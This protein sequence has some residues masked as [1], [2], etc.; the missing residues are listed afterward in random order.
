V[1]ANYERYH[2]KGFEVVGIS[3]DEDKD[4]LTDVIKDEDIPW[5]NLFE[6]PKDGEAGIQPTAEYYGISSLPTAILVGRDGKVLSLMARGEILTEL[7][8]QQF[9]KE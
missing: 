7:L 3:A 4:K 6:P 8:K 1:K 5:I 9:A 2:E